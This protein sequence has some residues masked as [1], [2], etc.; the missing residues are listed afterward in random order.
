MLTFPSRLWILMVC[1]IDIPAWSVSQAMD[2]VGVGTVA[3][4][5]ATVTTLNTS[6]ADLGAVFIHD[7]REGLP[8][9][10]FALDGRHPAPQV[11]DNGLLMRQDTNI[12]SQAIYL[13]LLLHGDFDVE[14][15]FSGLKCRAPKNGGFA[16]I[17][18][19]CFIE[20]ETYDYV[21]V[22]RRDHTGKPERKLTFSHGWLNPDGSRSYVEHHRDDDLSA[23]R[24][25]L[26]KRG[27]TIY[28]LFAVPDSD[29]FRVIQKTEV[30]AGHVGVQGLRLVV[31]SPPDPGIEVTWGTLK[32]RAEKFSGGPVADSDSIVTA[33]NVQRVEEPALYVDAADP[34]EVDEH[35]RLDRIARTV[36]EHTNDGL[37]ITLLSDN[38]DRSAHIVSELDEM[39]GFDVGVDLE[40]H[41]LEPPIPG[42][43]AC[44]V[45][46]QVFLKHEA[47]NGPTTP[48]EVA[49]FLRRNCD[50]CLTLSSRYTAMNGTR[51]IYRLIRTISVQSLNRMRI[52]R[53]GDRIVFMYG[54]EAADKDM[55]FAELFLRSPVSAGSVDL[56]SA[57]KGNAY[58]ADVTWKALLIS[59]QDQQ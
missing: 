13:S 33:I 6:A 14:V 53:L 15:S 40:L 9:E 5:E 32:V 2:E 38:G 1:V 55:A 28:G 54:D 47:P 25:R 3:T 34:D 37:R 42:Q 56:Y 26:A 12:G 46:L 30:P 45:G 4:R 57:A 36:R 22:I 39:P 16:G 29:A 8:R 58:I 7:F 35:F 21:G 43:T 19:G 24:F 10:Y 41:Q 52:A 51:K 11:T 48:D 59:G 20:A 44:E 49:L 23:G 18:L 27:N 17:Q 50:G 31:E